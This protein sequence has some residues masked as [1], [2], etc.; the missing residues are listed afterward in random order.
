VRATDKDSS[1]PRELWKLDLASR[2]T[3]FIGVSK[4]GLQKIT[5]DREGTRIVG[6]GKCPPLAVPLEQR[7]GLAGGVSI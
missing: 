3:E 6:T 7:S 1:V 2:V 5:L 4:P